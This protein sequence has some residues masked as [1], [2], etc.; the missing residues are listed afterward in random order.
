MICDYC[1]KPGHA[2]ERCVTSYMGIQCGVE[3]PKERK[4]AAQV[5]AEVSKDTAGVTHIPELTEAQYAK[6]LQ[7][8]NPTT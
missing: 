3:G 8:L 1:K 7:F 6:L 5:H 4:F 2:K